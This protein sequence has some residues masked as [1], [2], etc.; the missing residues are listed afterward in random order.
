MKK[1]DKA[2][3][4]FCDDVRKEASAKI[5]LMGIYHNEILVNEFPARKSKFCFCIFFDG[6]KKN[7]KTIR[8]VLRL[9]GSKD[10]D[11]GNIEQQKMV[12]GMNNL[13]LTLEASPFE[14]LEAGEICLL[15]YI[16]G[17]KTP[18]V[19]R[20]LTIREKP[21]NSPKKSKTKKKT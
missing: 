3:A 9:P 6:V 1:Y 19:I 4:I 8:V 14:V 15:V 21:K 7:F 18:S 16:D 17:A 5:S 20:R 13:S 10:L 12:S 2:Y 11:T